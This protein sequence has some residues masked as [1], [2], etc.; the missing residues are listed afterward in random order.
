[1]RELFPSGN[2][3]ESEEGKGKREKGRGKREEGRGKRE[4]RKMEKAKGPGLKPAPC[5]RLFPGPKGPGFLKP[6]SN[7]Q[8]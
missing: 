4:K 5:Q 8:G 3:T 6:L 2:Y 7:S 1:V